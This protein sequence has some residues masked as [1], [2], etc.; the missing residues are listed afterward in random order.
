MQAKK[1][2]IRL[3][4][5][6]FHTIFLLL[7][8][9]ALLLFFLPRF[10]ILKQER[11]PLFFYITATLLSWVGCFCFMALLVKA[12]KRNIIQKEIHLFVIIP[13][14]IIII[15]LLLGPLI[16]YFLGKSEHTL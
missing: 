15:V 3:L 4:N 14:V 12:L 7:V 16:L 2:L 13:A 5:I 6:P 11:S 10:D 9:D 1:W 8:A